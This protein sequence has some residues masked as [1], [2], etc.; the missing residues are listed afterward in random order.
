MTIS[1]FTTE[2]VICYKQMLHNYTAKYCTII[3]D[4][5]S[6]DMVKNKKF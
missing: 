4:N 3:T 2:F 6:N 5:P 1:K